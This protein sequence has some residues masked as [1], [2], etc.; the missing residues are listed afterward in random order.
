M[1]NIARITA[2]SYLTSSPRDMLARWMMS[3]R[4]KTV[5]HGT[6]HITRSNTHKSQKYKWCSIVQPHSKGTP[7][8]TNFSRDQILLVTCLVFFPDSGRRSTPLW[9]TLRKC[10]FKWELE[11][12]IKVSSDF[13]GGQMETWS[14]KLKSIVWLCTSL[15]PHHPLHVPTTHF[16]I[17]Q[18]T[19]KRAMEPR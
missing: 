3:A 13:C 14:R 19:T 18:T 12:K 2:A 5:G 7:W 6:C 1:T 10:S 11:R 8:M 4:I 9:R 17:Q 15:V 16:S